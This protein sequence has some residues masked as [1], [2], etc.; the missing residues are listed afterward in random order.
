MPPL[1]EIFFF[2]LSFL[3]ALH[4]TGKKADTAF[5]TPNDEHM[6][7]DKKRKKKKRISSGKMTGDSSRNPKRA[8][9]KAFSRSPPIQ[10]GV[11]VY[12][13]VGER[14]CNKRSFGP[15]F[16]G[17]GGATGTDVRQPLSL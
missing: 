17:L 1:M 11:C 12:L 14:E 7:F 3:V 6:R 13:C 4:P 9:V 5:G 16:L 8:L 2:F 10:Y 15:V